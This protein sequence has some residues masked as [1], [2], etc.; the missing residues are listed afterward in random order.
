MRI[1]DKEMVP[2]LS[3]VEKYVLGYYSLM[4]I[5]TKFDVND[6]F[7]PFLTAA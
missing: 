3:W 7:Y 6:L 2:N 5:N 1:R 4:I